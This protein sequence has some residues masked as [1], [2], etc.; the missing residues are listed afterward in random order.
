MKKIIIMAASVLLSIA[1]WGQAQIDTK[2][3]KIGDFN[4]KVT[5]VVL[6]GNPFHDGCL[7]SDVAAKWNASPFEF[8]TMEE[9]ENLKSSDEY[10][11]LLTTKGQFRKE[12]EPGL[13]FLTLVKGGKKAE[14]GIDEMLEVVS[15]PFSSADSPS[16][17]E[18][19]FLQI[20]LDIIQK[21]ALDSME[22]DIDAYTGL[23]NY[24]MNISKSG[25]MT[26][27]FSE[28]DLASEVTPAIR[29]ACFDE[30]V[31]VLP[32]EEA[33]EYLSPEK[34]NTLV[35][36]VV[37]PTETKPGSFC[38][39][40]LVDPQTNTLYSFR[41]HKVSKKFGPGFL[42]EDVKRISVPRRK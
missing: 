14:D 31:L 3:V 17:R 10:Y 30:K 26:L 24:S 27:V 20:I 18:Y 32:E 6:T 38:Y 23:P 40:M 1:A 9:Y 15:F 19:V 7:K 21:Y 25:D 2:K 4:Q 29:N 5:K 28:T 39:K 12:A 11:F 35:S 22:R 42:A 8:C 16:G 37:A 41:K 34:E 13:T 36:Y 33:D